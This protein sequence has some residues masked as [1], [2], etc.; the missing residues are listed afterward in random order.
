MKNNNMLH[1]EDMLSPEDYEKAGKTIA[2]PKAEKKPSNA[3]LYVAL[4]FF[5]FA[6]LVVDAISAGVVGYMTRWYYGA[7]TLF[8]GAV[9]MFVHEFL[10]TR[11]FN[12]T[13]QRNIAIGGAVWAV[14]TILFVALF[15]VVA[16][17]TGFFSA[18]YEPY[19]LAGMVGIILFNIVLHGSL[20]GV[21]YYV[22][23]EHF[24]KT[25]ATRA[26]AR[27]NTQNKID[28]A[29]EMI[30]TEALKRRINRKNMLARFVSPEALRLAIREAGGEDEDGDGI[31]DSI[32]PVDNR[33]G[34]PF[35]RQFVQQTQQPKEKD[36]T[37]PPR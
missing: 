24:A 2:E 21:F 4:I 9:F 8:A 37:N 27:A 36:P 20:A 15:T 22:D 23:D 1:G 17:L 11:P 32:D 7:S 25:K 35:V 13:R 31:P 33:T 28:E 3:G 10:F 12:N 30:L 34:K 6:F 18:Q 14:L 5:N 29:A 16:N 19:F 26:V